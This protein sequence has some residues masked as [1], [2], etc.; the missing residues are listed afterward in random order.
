MLSPPP[1]LHS[2]LVAVAVLVGV[3]GIWCGVWWVAMAGGEGRVEGDE[4]CV[5]GGG[6]RV[7]DGVGGG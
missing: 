4:R 2:T 3:L 1:I 6:W 5:A 7:A